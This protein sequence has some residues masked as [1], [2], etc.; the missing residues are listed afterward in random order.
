VTYSEE[1]MFPA[2]AKAQPTRRIGELNEIP[3]VA[4]WCSEQP[5]T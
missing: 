3:A 2:L 1:E 4:L 5:G